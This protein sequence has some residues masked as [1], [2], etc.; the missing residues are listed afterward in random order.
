MV[1]RL[2]TRAGAVLSV[3]LWVL[4]LATGIA[5]AEATRFLR[6]GTGGQ[7][8]TYYPIGSLM[9]TALTVSQNNPACA[10][11]ACGVSDLVTVAQLSGGSV[12]NIDGIVNGT[13]EAGLAQSDIV[14]WAYTGTGPFEG[15]KASRGLRAVANLYPESVHLVALKS[16]GIHTVAD[17]SGRRISLDDEGSGT[18]I[19]ARIVLSVFAIAEH[20]LR[21]QYVKPGIAVQRLSAGQL[22][23]FFMVG[24]FPIR[25][26]SDLASTTEI[27]LIPIAG[28]GARE[29][30]RRFPFFS[31]TVIPAGT[32]R[33]VGKTETISVNAQLIVRANLEEDLV[34]EI[35]RMLWSEETLQLLADGH[36]KGALVARES[37]LVGISI[38][39][40]AGARR[41][42]QSVGII[43]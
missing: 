34:Y 22:D 30:T 29:I 31:S 20:E 43:K 11:G 42:Y 40:H 24:G 37:A 21:A 33:G 2:A 23:A 38:P 3:A 18:L 8:G 41:Y 14:H 39:L 9:A 25:A 17:L 36:P 10:R 13:L 27:R 28:D 12:A 19:D 26:I 6:I 15:R 1:G 35:T 16:S 4:M 32:Y 5:G 7:G